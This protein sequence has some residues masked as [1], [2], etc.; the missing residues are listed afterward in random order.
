[1]NRKAVLV[2][3]L[4]FLAVPLIGTCSSHWAHP[5][6][7]TSD[8]IQMINTQLDTLHEQIAA[9]DSG[10][11]WLLLVLGSSILSPVILAVFLLFRADRMAIHNDEILQQLDQHGITSEIID[12]LR[13]LQK[14]RTTLTGGSR[15]RLIGAEREPRT[16]GSVDESDEA[17]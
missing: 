2:L 8:Q 11:V 14:P 5:S 6:N 9:V 15:L 1:M 4:V 12:T 13:L 10:G 16:S 7:V 3:S 17:G